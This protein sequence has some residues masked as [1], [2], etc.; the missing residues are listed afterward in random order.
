M[1]CIEAGGLLTELEK[2]EIESRVRRETEN[3]IHPV[4]E[5][6]DG[7]VDFVLERVEQTR[8][9]D[10][11]QVGQNSLDSEC[12]V[13]LHHVDSVK[14][15]GAVRQ[16]TLEERTILSRI[17][18]V[19]KGNDKVEIPSLKCKD[20]RLVM[21]EVSVVNSLLLN[22]A[23]CCDDV[24]DVNT[25]LY[26]GSYVVCEKLGVIKKKQALK[27]KKP[28]WLR[29][30]D[31]NLEVWR[32][33]LA[34]VNEVARGN[35]L[36][37]TSI[38]ELERRYQL[39]IKG[40]QSV[41]SLLKGKI[42]AASTK[43]RLYKEADLKKRQNNLF[44]SNQ[45]QLFKELGGKGNN[46]N[47]PPEP[48]DAKKFWADIWSQASD[49]NREAVWLPGVEEDLKDTRQQEDLEILLEDVQAVVKKMTNWKAPGPDGVRGFWFKKFTSLHPCLC[50]L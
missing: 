8:V 4:E 23:R 46:N 13:V 30:L 19:F 36:K 27:S 21:N 2:V 16:P 43:I 50:K 47:P 38:E 40:T 39:K 10:K 37:Q 28:W 3:G 12:K 18:E 25:L 26:A 7:D 22:V 33:D 17:R 32:R 35:R 11:D 15:N 45:R 48:E 41:I 49:F 24:T 1:K 31:R 34:R 29:R 6:S 42:T 9:V 14:V 5:E 20:R 44:K